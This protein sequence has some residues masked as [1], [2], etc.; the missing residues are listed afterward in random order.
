MNFSVFNF[1][2]RNAIV[3]KFM[4]DCSGA[5]KTVKEGVGEGNFWRISNKKYSGTN[6]EL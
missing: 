4:F 3:I 2:F 5:L 6:L 1:F